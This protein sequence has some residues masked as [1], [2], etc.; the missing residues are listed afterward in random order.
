M[1]ERGINNA[2]IEGETEI[3]LRNKH[4]LKDTEDLSRAIQ[5]LV[6]K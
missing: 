5:T 1:R 4:L 2:G 6:N 3:N